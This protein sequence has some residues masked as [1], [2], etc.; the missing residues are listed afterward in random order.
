MG[1]LIGHRFEFGLDDW[2]MSMT[3][4]QVGSLLMM[5]YRVYKPPFFAK[6][7]LQL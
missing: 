2:A 6:L 7:T 4:R 3:M 5:V 1:R